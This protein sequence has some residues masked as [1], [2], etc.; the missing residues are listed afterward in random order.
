LDGQEPEGAAARN[1]AYRSL[2]WHGYRRLG[3]GGEIFA[4]AQMWTGSP[5]L[6]P[7]LPKARTSPGE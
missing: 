7:T 3:V 2:A 5:I 1:R 4:L 6:T